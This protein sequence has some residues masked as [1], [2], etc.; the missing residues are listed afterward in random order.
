MGAAIRHHL[1]DVTSPAKEANS[2]LDIAGIDTA[3]LCN[4]LIAR[5]NMVYTVLAVK[6][7]PFIVGEGQ[8]HADLCGVVEATR[9]YRYPVFR[10]HD[11]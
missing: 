9:T 4:F 6:H 5:G 10:F 1:D 3:I 7:E 8:P 11:S 2:E